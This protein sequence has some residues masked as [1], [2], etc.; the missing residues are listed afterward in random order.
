M[1]RL[2]REAERIVESLERLLSGD[3]LE[4]KSPDSLYDH[5]SGTFREVDVSIKGK[6]G[7]HTILVVI[8][9]RDRKRVQDVTWIEQ[10]VSKKNG[11]NAN[12][13]IALSTSD[14]SPAAKKLAKKNG[15][16]LRFLKDFNPKEVIDWL[17]KTTVEFIDQRFEITDMSMRL[18]DATKRERMEPTSISKSNVT[19]HGSM[20]SNE[21]NFIVEST[22]KRF[23]INDIVSSSNRQKDNIFFKGIRPNAQP[24]ERRIHLHLGAPSDIL[25]VEIEGKLHRILEMNITAKFWMN[26]SNIPATKARRYVSEEEKYAERLDYSW[27]NNGGNEFTISFQRDIKTDKGNVEIHIGKEQ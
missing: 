9:C 22:G 6:I 2:G 23:S 19:H 11:I 4:I 21:L 8:E 17:N 27:T 15:I 1:A 13:M 20:K 16:E 7:S 18:I 24:I 5:N 26:I 25:L 12:K 3:L 10:L 14:L